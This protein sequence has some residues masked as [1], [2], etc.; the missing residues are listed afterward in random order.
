MPLLTKISLKT[1]L[2]AAFAVVSTLTVAVGAIGIMNM[3]SINNKAIGMYEKELKCLS[4]AKAAYIDLLLATSAEKSALLASTPD[5]RNQYLARSKRSLE[6]FKENIQKARPF[7]QSDKGKAL[8]TSLSLAIAEWEPVHNQVIDLAKNEALAEKRPSSDLSGGTGR[9]KVA[10]VGNI[11]EE[12]TRLQEENAREINTENVSLFKTSLFSMTGLTVV[13]F[14]LGLVFGIALSVSISRSL[15]GIIAGLSEGAEQVAAGSS[16]VAESSQALAEGASEQAASLEETSASTDQ[17]ASMTKHNADNALKAKSMMTEVKGIVTDVDRHI[18][19]MAGAISE[20]MKSSEET[21]KIVKTIDAIA[22]QT[23]LLALNA[24]VEA[25]R[26]GEKGAGFAVV[27]GEVRNLAMRSAEAAKSTSSLIETTLKNVKRGH[28]LTKVTQE[29]FRH[30]VE[31]AGKVAVIVD[32]VAAASGEQAQGIDQINKAVAEMEKLTQFTAANA[33]ESASA[34]EEMSAQAMQVKG[35]VEDLSALIDGKGS[36]IRGGAPGAEAA[37]V[38]ADGKERK[39]R[40]A[41]PEAHGR[42]KEAPSAGAKEGVGEDAPFFQ[43]ALPFPEEPASRQ[44]TFRNF[45][46]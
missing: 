15:R 11:L 38:I 46:A 5:Q 32:E 22:F 35:Y 44:D 4:S 43:G 7:F 24:A 45:D 17:L 25:A 6:S 31:L 36:G 16:Q 30:N 8:M 14:A 26:A 29:A 18:G 37:A 10:A 28:E 1:K 13:G 20:A 21:G 39:D 3:R 12:A 27:A 2:I 33:E 34:S 19:N 42:E 9:E 41:L 23:N 40:P